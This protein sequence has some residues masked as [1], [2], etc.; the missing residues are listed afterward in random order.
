MRD[1]FGV[2]DLEFWEASGAALGWSQRLQVD[3][4]E[5]ERRRIRS[6]TYAGRPLGSETFVEQCQRYKRKLVLEEVVGESVFVA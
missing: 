4:G 3:E 1:E 2:L 6:A 5:E